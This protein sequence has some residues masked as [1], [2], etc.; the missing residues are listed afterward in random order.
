M[1][2]I[3]TRSLS[4]LAVYA[5]K[6]NEYGVQQCTLVQFSSYIITAG[7]LTHVSI[8]VSAGLLGN[9]QRYTITQQLYQDF[10]QQEVSGMNMKQEDRLVQKFLHPHQAFTVCNTEGIKRGPD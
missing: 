5:E 1:K 7:G 3:D 9:L 6:L 4:D 2:L 10:L 8:Q